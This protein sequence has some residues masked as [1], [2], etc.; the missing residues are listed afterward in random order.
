MGTNASSPEVERLQRQKYRSCYVHILD[1]PNR[2]PATD[3]DA[4]MTVLRRTL[5]FNSY[6]HGS[7]LDLCCGTGDFLLDVAPRVEKAIGVDFSPEL[8][9]IA[10][11]RT[12]KQRNVSLCVGSARGIPL[13]SGSIALAFS[14]SSLYYI[15]RVEKV[16]R[17]C[18]RVLEGGGTAILEFGILHSLNSI[19]CRSYPD[20]ASPCHVPL[21]AARRML[22]SAGLLL[23]GDHAFQLLPLWGSKPVWLRPL[24]HPY[25]KRLLS[26]ETRNGK[27]LDEYFSSFWPLRNFA[28]RHIMVCRK[29]SVDRKKNGRRIAIKKH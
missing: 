5:I 8:V 7:V 3:Y 9:N 10:R 6:D 11:N 29:S 20:L 18:A 16:V 13:R 19:V 17:E 22:E 23:V 14:F 26:L 25:W 15:P 4:K 28:F 27:M 2:T 1:R 24:L 12:S 21:L